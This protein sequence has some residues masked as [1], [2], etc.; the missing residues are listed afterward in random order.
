MFACLS[1]CVLGH[2]WSQEKV[3]DVLG[4]EFHHELPGMGDGDRSV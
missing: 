1:L 2:A 3:L 4:L